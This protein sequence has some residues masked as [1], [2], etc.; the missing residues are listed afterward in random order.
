MT[1]AGS[2]VGRARARAGRRCGALTRVDLLTFL[3][4]AA[5]CSASYCLAIWHNGRGAADSRVLGPGAVVADA[6]SCGRDAR[7]ED[8][9]L[10]F[11]AH[12]TAEGARLSVSSATATTSTRRALRGA[13]WAGNPA[14]GAAEAAAGERWAAR[15]DG[16][17]LRFTD[18]G[19]VRA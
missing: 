16:D 15:V 17:S 2:P 3:F 4:A 5:L 7:A 19:A 9:P 18:A 13:V 1:N 14:R 10:D 8:E 12:H 6:T 11:E